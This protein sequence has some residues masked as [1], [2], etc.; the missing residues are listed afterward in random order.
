[1]KNKTII[2]CAI[3]LLLGSYSCKK[4][5]SSDSNTNY[6]DFTN[7]KVTRF[8]D[9]S[10]EQKFT[11]NAE[12]KISKI[13]ESE[14]GSLSSTFTYTYGNSEV[15]YE[16]A[17]GREKGNYVLNAKGYVVSSTITYYQD[18]D[19]TKATSGKISTYKYN[20]AGNLIDRNDS[21]SSQSG[22]TNWLNT[23]TWANGNL[24]TEISVSNFGSINITNYEYYTDKSNALGKTQ[25]LTDFIGVPSKNLLKAEKDG[26]DGSLI[27]WYSYEFNSSG[28]PT[29]IITNEMG[30]PNI[31]NLE[32]SC[33]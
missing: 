18:M 19:P 29:K 32:L 3:L 13:E 28:K 26:E 25:T 10:Y 6:P 8:Y 11:Y 7:C 17:T 20:D 31:M 14:S 9:D 33:P 15:N 24:M 4:E 5:N 12:G 23:Y 22:T 2:I 30:S 27:I 21:Y 16:S 1:V